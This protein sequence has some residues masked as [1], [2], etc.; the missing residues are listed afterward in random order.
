M[1]DALPQRDWPAGAE[2]IVAT[3]FEEGGKLKRRM[4]RLHTILTV[5]SGMLCCMLLIILPVSYH[6]NLWKTNDKTGKLVPN[7]SAITITPRLKV[8]L[9]NGGLLIFSREV[10]YLAGTRHLAD[11]KGILYKGG[12]AR[13]VREAFWNVYLQET[14]IGERGELVEIDRYLNLPGIYYRCFKMSDNPPTDWTLMMEL[15]LLII[16]SG[17]LPLNFIFQRIRTRKTRILDSHDRQ[18]H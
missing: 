11:E 14:L 9:H 15:W 2:K 17:I 5:V 7:D 8:E 10:P 4:N 16:A 18:T 12:H 3:R 13:A 1:V 6:F